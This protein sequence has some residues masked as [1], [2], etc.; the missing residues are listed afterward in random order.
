VALDYPNNPYNGQAFQSGGFRWVWDGQKWNSGTG[1]GGQVWS[2]AGRTGDVVLTSADITDWSTAPF[3]PLAGGVM[4]GLLTLSGNASS[5]LQ[6]VPL[7]QLNSVV[8]GFLPLSG[9]TLTGALRISG[10]TDVQ[11]TT[12]ANFTPT[13]WRLRV[14]TGDEANAGAIDYRGYDANAL[15]IIG[16]GTTGTNRL[17]HIW[18]N[19]NVNGGIA[20][21]SG[22]VTSSGTP[23]GLV[24]QDRAGG[25]SGYWTWY[26]LSNIARLYWSGDL[27]TFDTGGN[28]HAN[29]EV[30]GTH[31][32]AT[33]GYVW[34]NG[35]Q[36]YNRG[37]GWYGFN[38]SFRVPDFYSDGNINT[39]GSLLL[40][41]T[42][43]YN[44]AGYMYTPNGLGANGDIYSN[45]SVRAGAYLN[46]GGCT[47]SN[48]GG[49]MYS[50]QSVQSNGNLQAN[51]GVVYIAG[52]YWQN[53]GG[54]MYCPWQVRTDGTFQSGSNMNC[55]NDV[56]CAGV[57]RYWGARGAR[58]ECWGGSWGWL[59][60]AVADVVYFSPDSGGSGV[61]CTYTGFSDARLKDNIRDTQVD[62]LAAVLAIPV[63]E[64]EWKDE[65][66]RW[67]PF[68]GSKVSIGIVAQELPEVMSHTVH[69]A[70]LA[71]DSLYI[72]DQEVTP[73]LIR[74]IQQLTE[75]LEKLEHDRLH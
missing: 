41:G 48:N 18:D 4:T 33:A 73:Y 42:Q 44:N 40:N 70:T 28:L 59:N 25:G 20:A 7:Q 5:A 11:G 24:F 72:H 26:S 63:R 27:F 2:V 64:F 19:L 69:T 1:Q 35:G 65:A 51:G 10:G 50:P 9:G 74:A 36:L 21:L 34:V 15:G 61:Y 8:G 17:V 60:L 67:M 66:H 37:D 14:N 6:A 13:R 22:T 68:T 55:G 46:C 58:L 16:A 12:F 30:Y 38:Q 57:F 39:P 54:W 53:N 49:W 62:A 3:V 45:N 29:G 32:L 52:M 43:M 71:G 23:A 47:W 31:S 75:R 56:N